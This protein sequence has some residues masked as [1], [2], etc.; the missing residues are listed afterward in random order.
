MSIHESAVLQESQMSANAIVRNFGILRKSHGP[1][2]TNYVAPDESFAST[3]RSV[4][5]TANCAT[6]QL[7]RWVIQAFQSR[8]VYRDFSIKST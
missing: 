1:L 7:K 2:D 4:P 5:G 3:D 6:P 8:N